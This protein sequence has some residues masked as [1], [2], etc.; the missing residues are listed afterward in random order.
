VRTVAVVRKVEAYALHI[1]ILLPS[2]PN[3]GRGLPSEATAGFRGGPC[4]PLP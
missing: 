4:Q 3:V 2:D 1:A